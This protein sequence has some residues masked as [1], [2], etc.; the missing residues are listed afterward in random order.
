MEFTRTFD[1]GMV[2]AIMRHKAL[3]QVDDF[4]PPADEFWPREDDAIWYVLV[5]AGEEILGLF[6]L[7]PMN[8]I[9]WEIHTRLLPR[10]WG[11]LAAEAAQGILSWLWAETPVLRIVT[12]VPA[13]NRLAVRF[14]QRAGLR[15]FGENPGSFLKD[16][17]LHDQILLGISKPD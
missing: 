1:F 7:A 3:Y 9:T 14:A 11:K 10:A 12:S 8:A 17:R 16:G 2:A 4:G 6:I 5:T 15:V 13:Y